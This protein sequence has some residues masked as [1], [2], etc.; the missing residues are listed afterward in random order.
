MQFNKLRL[1]GFKSFVDPTELTIDPGLTGIVGPNGCGKSNLV[2]AIRWVMG[3]SSAKQLRG[4]EMDAVIFGGTADRPARSIAEV[5]LHLDNADRRAPPQFNEFEALEVARRIEREHGSAYSVNGREIRARDVQLMFADLATGARSSALVSQGRVGALIAAK[6]SSRRLLLEEAA[7]ITGLH[8]RRH[9]A[10]LRLRGAETNLERLDDVLQ[11]LEAQLKSLKKQ[12]RQAKRFRNLG[13][14]IR[15]AEAIVLHLRWAEATRDADAARELLQTAEAAVAALTGRVAAATTERERAATELPP[16]RQAEAVAAAELQR[17]VLAQGALV[18]EEQRIER[19][20][21]E[22]EQRLQQVGDDVRREQALAA[23]AE[24]SEV[25]LRGEG[26]ALHLA[27]DSDTLL[28][29]E[30][31]LVLEKAEAVAAAE[32]E[33]YR[34]AS[35]RLAADEARHAALTREIDDLDARARR[36][37]AR[38]TDNQSE[39]ASLDAA[40]GT[41]ADM[42]AAEAALGAAEE[43]AER[44]RARREH[45]EAQQAQA[46]QREIR[47]NEAYQPAFERRNRLRAEAAALI[48]LLAADAAGDATPVVDSVEVTPGY[49]AALAAAFGDDL[50]A[51]EDTSA[52][53][54]WRAWPDLDHPPG[55]PDGA[56]ALADHVRA[57]AVLRRR[58]S[59]VGVV[60]AAERGAR[61]AGL[62]LQGQRLVSV[63]GHLWRW[64]GL[65]SA[66]SAN[67]AASQRLKH[68][69]RLSALQ[70]E[71]SEAETLNDNARAALESARAA[72]ASALEEA[73]GS[74]DALYAAEEIAKAARGNRA[75]LFEQSAALAARRQSL[76]ETV[77]RLAED[78]TDTTSRHDTARQALDEL[79]DSSAA[80][81]ARDAA[82]AQLNTARQAAAAARA[83]HDAA[84]RKAEAHQQR[85]SAI[86]R[87]MR[88]WGERHESAAGRIDELQARAVASNAELQALADEPG[89]IT[90]QRTTLRDAIDAAEQQRN[91]LADDLAQAEARLAACEKSLKAIEH[92]NLTSREERIRAEARVAQC[93]QSLQQVRE[94]VAE[95]LNCEPDSTRSIAGIEDGDALPEATATETRLER[96]MRERENIGPVNLRAEQEAAELDEKITGLLT[97]REDLMAAI[98]RLRQG[99]GSLNREGRE[100]LLTSFNE[101]DSHFR[102]LF[103]RLFSGGSAKLAL[104]ESDDPLEAGL[105]VYA[106]P[107]GKRLQALSLLSG[108]EQA[109]TAIAL[110]FAVFLTNPAPICILDEVD[111]PLDDANVDRFCTML[112]DISRAT[113]TRFLLVTH[114]RMTMARMDRLYGVT[115]AERGVSQLVSVDL[116]GAE[117]LRQ[118]A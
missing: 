36:L 42:A 111:A 117:A 49:E 77:A 64:D 15:R 34:A 29:E 52:P 91:R 107:P 86:E 7:G 4:G 74:R 35:D 78:R 17:L 18:A 11:T 33:S 70:D 113:Q 65:T 47:A 22:C 48:D 57:P 66:P 30:R 106:S 53:I 56:T 90:A 95:R 101:V 109:L 50:R 16:L 24:A 115:M 93:E 6:P 83:D 26:E 25:S 8:S 20:R 100:R 2:E 9:E 87:E 110:L 62:L 72:L 103:T 98:R 89:R 27:A 104:V 118:T 45:T 71:L 73:R 14:Q 112:G 79:G 31:R 23:E 105:E 82:R 69:A 46:Q 94:R 96:L 19:A 60:D 59:Q 3:E 81:L 116:R 88:S 75:S 39:L 41:Q 68:R 63:E 21:N 55:L 85:A 114:H 102:Q 97:E 99:I 32:E 13:E 1:H 108:G 37:D 80:R 61:L 67:S 54:H 10:E 76:G 5:V 84:I 28:V 58:L 44:A 43:S 51:P 38:L 12:V 40:G 92:D